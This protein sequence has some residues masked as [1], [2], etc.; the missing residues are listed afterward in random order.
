M[1]VKCFNKFN[2][3]VQFLLDS[4]DRTEQLG[5]AALPCNCECLGSACA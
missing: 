4:P 1:N 5:V 2:T 3:A